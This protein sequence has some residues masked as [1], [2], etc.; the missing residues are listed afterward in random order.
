[1]LRGGWKVRN[2][3]TQSW[4]NLTCKEIYGHVRPE[5]PLKNFGIVFTRHTTSPLD[6]DNLAG[7]FKPIMD[8]LKVA[9]IIEDDRWSMTEDVK[10]KQVR[11]SKRKEHHISVLVTEKDEEK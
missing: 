2:A 8:A 6:V 11:V 10:F 3:I 4:K 1:M 9:G 5:K 7:S